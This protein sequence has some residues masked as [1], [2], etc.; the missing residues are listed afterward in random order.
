LFLSRR[1]GDTIARGGVTHGAERLD[2]QGWPYGSARTRNVN[3]AL[4]HNRTFAQLGLSRCANRIG[5]NA[6]L[7]RR[8]R[9]K[10]VPI[11]CVMIVDDCFAQ[12]YAEARAKFL[13][14]SADLGLPLASYSPDIAG[15]DGEQLAMDTALCG[16]AN[17]NGLLI[18]SSGCHGVEGFCGSGIQVALLQDSSWHRAVRNSGCAVLYLHAVNPFGFSWW[19]RVTE[20]NVDLNR[21]FQNFNQPLPGNPRY[22]QIAQLLVPDQWPPSQ[23]VEQELQRFIAIHGMQAFQ[24]TVSSGQYNHPHGL[25]YGGRTATWSQRTLRSILRSAGQ[26]CRQLAW[27]DLH[28]GLGPMGH[29]EKIYAGKNEPESLQRARAWWQNV[30]TSTYDGSASSSR[31]EG[32]M[33]MSAYQECPQAEF[34]GVTLEYGTQPLD[35][36]L[37]ALRAE[38]WLS[39][40]ADVD[41]RTHDAI[42][43]QM[44]DAFYV[45]T[46]EWKMAVVQQGLQAVNDG[47]AGLA[48]A[49]QRS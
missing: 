5:H 3:R 17:A 31:V 48:A 49:A 7:L 12:S 42:K 32:L 19:R 40:T 33:L 6:V 28:S 8:A 26:A 35:A 4:R 24:D 37:A 34:T 23:T 43:R 45:D 27:I 1:N 22:D 36:I 18:V 13:R 47:L 10:R 2:D 21:N 30:V 20:G 16:P 9:K 41:R 38:Q 14:A 15:R 46:P 29:G 25:F 44:R 39:N 11:W